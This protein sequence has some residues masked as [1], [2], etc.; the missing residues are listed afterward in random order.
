MS[1]TPINPSLTLASEA[2][3][4]DTALLDALGDRHIVLVGLM[5]AGKSSVG[6][7][8]AT[9]IG[10]N[11]IDSDNAIED[12]AGM[13]IPEIF[14]I[15]GETEFRAGERRVIMRLLNEPRQV[16]ATGGG[17][18][19]DDQTRTSIKAQGIS[20]WLKAELPVLMKRVQRRHDRPMLKGDN[21]GQIMRDL[22]EKR[23]PVYAEADVT[24]LSQDQSHD[25]MVETVI[26]ALRTHLAPPLL[27]P[28]LQVG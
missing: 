3:L 15:R 27:A 26:S 16:I 25:V 22:M 28:P 4:L 8:L 21:P 17:A 10:L 14:Q 13:S 6:R 7:R 9:R 24:V 1:E 2:A 12:A 23:Y 18:Y 5:G 19:M 20:L 11:F